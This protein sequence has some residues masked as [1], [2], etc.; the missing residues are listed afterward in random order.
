MYK[1]RIHNELKN[2]TWTMNETNTEVIIN[3]TTKFLLT[4]LYPFKSPTLMI[5]NVSHVNIIKKKLLK[6]VDF[7]KLCNLQIPCFCCQSILSSWCPSY[8]CKDIYKE[9][10]LYK[11]IIF[12][13]KVLNHLYKKITPDIPDIIIKE[14]YSY[15]I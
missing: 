7:C 8:T 4:P 2:T 13:V 3:P 6:Y 14:I 15:L 11:K 10:I 5:S 1:R 9:Y 12:Y